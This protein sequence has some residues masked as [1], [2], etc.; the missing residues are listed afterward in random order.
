MQHVHSSPAVA[1]HQLPGGYSR[2]P[3]GESD[4]AP[5]VSGMAPVG[6]ATAAGA[7]AGGVGRGPGGEGRDVEMG[8]GLVDGTVLHVLLQVHQGNQWQTDRQLLWT[9]I[10]NQIM[11]SK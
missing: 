1:S 6:S 7:A 2:W 10:H 8:D 3:T 11:R 5:S 9:Y 4:V